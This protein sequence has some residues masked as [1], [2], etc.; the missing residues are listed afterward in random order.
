MIV[1]GIMSGTSFD[2]L[3]L[4]C[5]RFEPGKQWSYSLQKAETIP[6]NAYWQERLASLPGASGV[7]L[8]QADREYGQYIG[9][10]VLRFIQENNL[11]P[12]LIASHG[13]T[14]FHQPENGFTLQIGNGQNIAAETGLPVVCDFRSLDVALGGQGAPL[15]PVGDQLLFREYSY[16]LN[17][18]GFGNVS[19]NESKLGRVAFDICP[20]NIVL[21]YLSGMAGKE[22]DEKGM[23]ASEGQLN[24]KLLNSLNQLDYYQKKYPKSL[25]KEWVVRFVIPLFS[26]SGIGLNDMLHTFVIHIAEQIGRSLEING[27]GSVLVTGGGAYNEFLIAMLRNNTRSGINIP[28]NDLVNYKEAIVFA[29]LG[30]LRLR[31]EL[32]CLASVTGARKDSCCGL[33]VYPPN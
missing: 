20:V 8:I 12:D 21:N 9:N 30:L 6:Y 5:C 19:F 13:H 15:V 16:C 14:I 18:G 33:L 7:D 3:D 10:E 28:D 27:P 2:G 26:N 31:N 22:F 23:M 29:F 25:G 11:K 4:A 1:I 24:E 17:L 32:N